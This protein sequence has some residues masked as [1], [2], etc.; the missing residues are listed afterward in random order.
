MDL[1]KV[2]RGERVFAVTL[3][4]P[5]YNILN[6]AMLKE[7]Q[8]ALRELLSGH[9]RILL[10]RS[11]EKAFSAGADIKEHLPEQVREMIPTFDEVFLLMHSFDGISAACVNGAALGGGCELAL[12]CD[13]VLATEKA[14]FGQPEIKLGL[15]PPVALAA[16]PAIFSPK[17][18][19]DL[20]LSGEPVSAVEAYRLGFI[21]K[22]L[23]AANFDEEARKYLCRFAE[24]SDSSFQITKKMFKKLHL[25]D[26]PQKLKD[27]ENLYLD[28][29][30]QTEDA[31]E[32]LTAFLEKRKPVWRRDYSD[33]H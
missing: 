22:L 19:L 32:G 25:A 16:Y 4:N 27:A 28:V 12:F 2:E 11:G 10:F 15:F 26:F 21:N 14:K 5:P 6:I 8:E 13:V 29:L 3:S 9:Y 1:I 30:A 23:D 7:I 17:A 31:T 33:I 20:I 24:L 18:A